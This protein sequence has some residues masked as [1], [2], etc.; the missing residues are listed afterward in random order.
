MVF[1]NFESRRE[2]AVVGLV[3]V[4]SL[5]HPPVQ[6]C[7]EDDGEPSRFRCELHALFKKVVVGI[8]VELAGKFACIEIYF[9]ISFLEFIQ[10][11][12]YDDRNENV[13]FLKVEN[14][15]VIVKEDIRVQHKIFL[16]HGLKI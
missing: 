1:G 6:R 13:V 8:F 5:A 3:F 16:S 10:F 9:F 12:Q 14:A 4:E 11:F 15:L 2:Y 7:G